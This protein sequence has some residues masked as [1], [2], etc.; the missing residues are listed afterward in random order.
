MRT[1]TASLAF[2]IVAA[3]AL[4]AGPVAARSSTPVSITLDVHFDPESEVITAQTNFCDGTAESD[5]W[6]SGGGRNEGGSLAFHV[7][8]VFTCA[9]GVSS[10]TIELDAAVTRPH[11][12][13]SGGWRVIAGTG[14]YAGATGGGSI[15]GVFTETGIIDQYEG[16]I[17][18]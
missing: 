14:D 10:L 12:G 9:D 6:I 18:R 13:T 4:V 8:R 2:A 7:Y 5:A 16:T 15:V 11:G 17:V 3:V 1:R